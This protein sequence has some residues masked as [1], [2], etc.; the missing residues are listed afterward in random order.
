MMQLCNRERLSDQAMRSVIRICTAAALAT[1]LLTGPA[2]A[3]F[4]SG[5]KEKSGPQLEDEAKAKRNAEIDK[6]YRSMRKHT[7][8]AAKTTKTDP[9]QNMRAPTDSATR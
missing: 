1:T 4:G 2:L 3:Q 7:E 6:E 9:W 8:G 5:E